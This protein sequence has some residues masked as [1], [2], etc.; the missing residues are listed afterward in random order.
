MI[1]MSTGHTMKLALRPLILLIN[2]DCHAITTR[3]LPIY[4]VTNHRMH[5]MVDIAYR[6]LN[7]RPVK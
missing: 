1:R 6:S 3:F 4:L 5:T 7:Q 2:A